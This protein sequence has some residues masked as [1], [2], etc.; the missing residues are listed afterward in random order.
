[1]INEERLFDVT[2]AVA[3][4]VAVAAAAAAGAGDTSAQSNKLNN[5]TYS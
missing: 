2:T 5:N 1:M 3:V 4:A